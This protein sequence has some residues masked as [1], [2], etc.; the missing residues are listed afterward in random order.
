MQKTPRLGASQQQD[1]RFNTIRFEGAP[2]SKREHCCLISRARL[3]HREATTLR[4][5][6]VCP[7]WASK[8]LQ[9]RK[10][11]LAK[12]RAEAANQESRPSKKSDA[13]C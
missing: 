13:I 9:P 10:W 8:N 3:S 6:A 4:L 11:N 1:Y 2:S 7:T 5:Q 12:S